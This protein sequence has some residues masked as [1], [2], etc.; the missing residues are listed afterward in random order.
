[1]QHSAP[2]IHIIDKD[3][4]ELNSQQAGLLLKSFDHFA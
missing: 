1:M 4:K 2:E 3:G